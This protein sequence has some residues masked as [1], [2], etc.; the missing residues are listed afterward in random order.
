[1]ANFAVSMMFKAL[2]GIS[3]AFDKWNKKGE[4]LEKS[5][6]HRFAV[7]SASAAGFKEVFEGSLAAK[8][9]EVVLSKLKELPAALDEFAEKGEK[10]GK[11]SQILGLG[12]EDFQRLGYAAHMSDISAESLE[13]AF[14]KLN[15]G[16]G[17]IHKMNG[18]LQKGLRGVD[19]GLLVTM[20]SAKSNK[21]AFMDVANAIQK[22]T[23]P[24]K[25]AAIVTA[26]F[27]KAGQDLMPFLLRGKEGIA[28]LM[29]ETDKYQAVLST[30]AIEASEKFSDSQ[31]RL[32]AGIQSVGVSIMS[33]LLPKINPLLEKLVAWVA[34]NKDLIATKVT[35][36][37]EG[38]AN[39]IQQVT[40]L[41]KFV[42][43]TITWLVG[44]QGVLVAFYFAWTAAQ[45]ALSIAMDAN[46][47]G[48]IV[49]GI[50]ALIAA[51]ALLII[52]W[53]EF[54][55]FMV[56]YEWPLLKAIG[57]TLIKVLITPINWVI[58]AIKVLFDVAG[59]V[60]GKL[61]EPFRKAGKAVQDFQDQYNKW[62]TGTTENDYAGVWKKY[63]DEVN[64]NTAA[65]K[66]NAA[67]KKAAQDAN[68]AA[69]KAKTSILSGST[70]STSTADERRAPNSSTLA[71]QS[72]AFRA[73]TQ[74]NV[75]NSR[76]SGVISEVRV[77]HEFASDPRPEL[78]RV[79]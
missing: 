49:L 56:N 15:L 38:V 20:R 40:P 31:K 60:P 74:V 77:A 5:Q 54:S 18:P 47:M 48:A 51:I 65:T 62:M 10:I 75:D 33:S 6:K 12:A 36:F 34:K 68:A 4:E 26:V 27:G 67:A 30:E 35:A 69:K 41:F 52:N 3:P 39:G 22:T 43:D 21:E 53:R 50:E 16:M 19:S 9:V 2:D 73:N 57:N 1:M 70:G 14:K 11:T 29:K 25:R 59:M 44:H 79:N 78:E 72:A 13:K 71:A 17:S 7:M 61:G 24:T 8:G 37:I 76:A 46:P 66:A 58:D 45:I 42:I 63:T 32:K 23:D 55:D 64:R 28:A